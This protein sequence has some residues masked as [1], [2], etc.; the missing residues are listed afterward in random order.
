MR[1][2]FYLIIDWRRTALE[3]AMRCP[4]PLEL[5]RLLLSKTEREPD[6][7]NFYGPPEG[8][9]MWQQAIDPLYYQRPLEERVDLAC[10]LV[11]I[12]NDAEVFRIALNCNRISPQ[13][14]SMAGKDWEEALHAVTGSMNTSTMS[15]ELS[16]GPHIPYQAGRTGK[17][18]KLHL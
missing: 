4:N 11:S 5:P 13:I 7:R 17:L 8:F 6:L 1:L 12:G 18:C 9:S 16:P 2:C 15:L 14:L 10:Y 3:F